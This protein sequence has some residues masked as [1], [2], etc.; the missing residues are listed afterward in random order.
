[1]SVNLF[2]GKT[3][4]GKSWLANKLSK[5]Y[6]KVVFYDNAH[7]FN[8]GIIINDFSP[9]NFASI[10]KKYVFADSFRLIFRTPLN[11][12]DKEGAERV[13]K[14]FYNG[15]GTYWREHKIKTDN[16][17][18]VVDEADKIADIKKTSPFY[19][20]VTK[21]RHLFIDTFAIS[22]G[23]GCMPKYFKTNAE[24]VYCFKV[25][26]D[27]WVERKFGKAKA[28]EIETLE[29]HNYVHWKDTGE[30]KLVNGNGKVVKSWN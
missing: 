19:L 7:C 18:F 12:D 17:C 26:R 30:T 21:G 23:P 22:Q 4:S 10:F 16:I 8:E 27:E 6:K 14:L 9:K 15:F 29:V 24:E 3:K 5:P 2:F 13:A 28:K 1:M 25:E 20:M 11:M